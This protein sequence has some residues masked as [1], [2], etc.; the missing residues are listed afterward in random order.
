M[1]GTS[2]CGPRAPKYHAATRPLRLPDEEEPEENWYECLRGLT[3][4]L[5]LL[6]EK[7]IEPLSELT[8]QP[9]DVKPTRARKFS[10]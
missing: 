1:V 8:T 6:K 3:E 4:R 9:E 7:G 5:R 2:G 10:P